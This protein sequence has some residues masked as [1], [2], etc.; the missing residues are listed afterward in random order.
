MLVDWEWRSRK[1]RQQKL[2]DFP[3]EVARLQVT[4]PFLYAASAA[5]VTYSWVMEFQTDLAGPLIALFFLGLT[6]TG[7]TN[8][9]NTLVV[10]CHQQRPATAATANNLFRCLF[11][12][13][14][15]AVAVLMIDRIGV[16]WTGNFVTGLWIAFSPGLW[17]VKR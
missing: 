17:A 4:L 3:L 16:G 8:S 7:A 2:S 1:N 13:G 6:I 11:G 12:S 5:I 15:V 10:D 9:L 14:A